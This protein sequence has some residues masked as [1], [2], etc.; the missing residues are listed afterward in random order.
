MTTELKTTKLHALHLA[1]GAK[2]VPFAGYDMPI[3]YSD[4]ILAEHHH[5]RQ[6]ASLFDVSHMGI[7]R[8]RGKDA[9]SALEKLV[10]ADLHAMRRMTMRYSFM[11]N[12]QGGIIDDLMIT[13]EEE[14]VIHLVINAARREADIQHLRDHLVG[15]LTLEVEDDY[16][17]VALQGPAAMRVLSVLDTRV[18]DIAFMTA[19]ELTLKGTPCL[20]SRS[21]YTG[22]DGYEIKIPGALAEDFV[23]QLLEDERLKLAGLGARDSLRLEACLLLYGSDID[24]TTT[25]IEAGLLW[26]IQPRRR[27]EGGFPG[28]NIIQN[29]IEQG[30]ARRLVGLI[31]DG[32]APLRAGA[33]LCDES[34][35]VIGRVTSG[36]FGPSVGG[37]VAMAYV[38]SAFAEVGTE[39]SASVRKKIRPCRVAKM[40]FARKKYARSVTEDSFIK[41]RYSRD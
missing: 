5:T 6:S 8:V 9:I 14:D 2:M 40:P 11:T 20:V 3:Q 39:I 12:D 38:D 33:E 10:P 26:A 34:G 32:R 35:R 23:A 31:P 1:Q 21:G 41:K 37:P 17:L 13:R 22:E 29:Q 30:A 16:A 36:G 15:D 19:R 7:V 27:R 4:G 24:T 18:Q 25:P 28:A